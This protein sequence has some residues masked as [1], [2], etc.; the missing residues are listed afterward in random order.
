MGGIRSS[1][2]SARV[3]HWCRHRGHESFRPP[4]AELI[5]KDALRRAIICPRWMCRT[6]P[7]RTHVLLHGGIPVK[8]NEIN[9]EN[10]YLPRPSP[11]SFARS[12]NERHIISTIS[13][14]SHTNCCIVQQNFGRGERSGRV[15]IIWNTRKT[16]IDSLTYWN[17]T[18][19]DVIWKFWLGAQ[20]WRE[21]GRNLW[22]FVEI[23]WNT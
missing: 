12:S 3:N 9:L 11:L 23:K 7:W 13:T 8:W 1:V 6:L 5:P 4:Q 20:I 2:P 21:V 14:P 18:D 17:F 10:S 15:S 16:A 22:N 19:E